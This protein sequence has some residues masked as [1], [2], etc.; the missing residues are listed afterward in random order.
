[1]VWSDKRALFACTWQNIDQYPC[2][3]SL[4]PLAGDWQRH[5]TSRLRRVALSDVNAREVR[6]HAI[7]LGAVPAHRGNFLAR[8]LSYLRYN[9]W[10]MQPWTVS[11][12]P[13]YLMD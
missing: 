12:F 11:N 1:M 4:D 6:N 13:Q 8:L 3:L 7:E 5:R 9:N 10:R 2:C